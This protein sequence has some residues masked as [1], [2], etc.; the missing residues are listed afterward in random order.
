MTTQIRNHHD[1]DCFDLLRLLAAY[2]VLWSHQ[3]GLMKLPE[4]AWLANGG[5][6]ALLIFFSISGYLNGM[7]ILRKPS[8]WQFLV[9]RAKR[10]FPGA[11]GAALFCAI[12]GAF[13]TTADLTRYAAAAVS[14]VL[15]NTFILFGLQFNL[16]GV[17]ETNPYLAAVNGSLWSLVIELRFYIYLAIVA[18]LVRYRPAI[19]MALSLIAIP[20]LI[21][22]FPGA[23]S[24]PFGIVFVFGVLIA[25]AEAH[26]KH[27]LLP[28]VLAAALFA[29]I[30]SWL[31]LICLLII[32]AGRIK[33]HTKQPPIDISY[34]VY[35]YAF[36][37][38]QFIISQQIGFWPGLGLSLAVAT[39]LGVLSA[40]LIEQPALRWR[41]DGLRVQLAN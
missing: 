37:V 15:K 41:I 22:A 25:A 34:G 1:G 33:I 3:Y 35:L 6:A 32:L 40:L 21:L 29:A 30:G 36:P 8:W 12:I 5:E 4:P 31:P 10:I 39:A 20:M 23:T 18:L 2:M 7:S 24:Q 27:A 9:R 26:L 38:Q 28:C 11:A 14:F 19:L 13:L 16:P 17:F